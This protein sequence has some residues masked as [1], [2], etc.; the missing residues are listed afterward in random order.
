MICTRTAF[1]GLR[2]QFVCG[3][4]A[5]VT[6][7]SSLTL[8]GVTPAIA[9]TAV[10]PYLMSPTASSERTMM[11]AVDQ[12][13]GGQAQAA[14]PQQ[15]AAPQQSAAPQQGDVV[16]PLSGG[17]SLSPISTL[18]DDL[19]A[20]RGVPPFG[21][22][23]FMQ[24]SQLIRPQTVNPNYV[25]TPGDQIAIQIWGAQAFSGTQ[26]VDPQGN[27]FVP[28]IGPVAVAGRTVANVNA[29]ISAAVRRVFTSNVNAYVTVLSRQPVGVYVSGAVRAP[30]HYAGEPNGSPLGF[31]VQA[32]GIDPVSGSFRDI[33]LLR[34]GATVARI[35]L[36]AFLLSG[37]MPV[38]EFRENDSLFVGR[39][40]PSVTVH[41]EAQNCFRFEIPS[42]VVT[43]TD[44]VALARPQPAASHV[45]LR[46]VR[47]NRPFNAYLPLAEFRGAAVE[48]GDDVTFITDR[49]TESIVVSVIGQ[50]GGPSS[51]AVPRNAPLGEVLKL[52]E[53]DPAT[54][55]LSS[56]YLRRASVAERQAR[57][58]EMSLGELQ[59][60]ALTSTATTITEAGIRNQEA[61]LIER[62]IAK[63][64][65]ARPE[66]RVVLAGTPDR[67]DLRLE[68]NDVIVLPARS[69]VVIIAGEV[70]VPQTLMWRKG[71]S[72]EDYVELAG[73]FSNR[74]SRGDYVI[75][76]RNG[77]ALIGSSLDV[78]PGDQVMVMPSPGDKGFAV[79]HDL[80]EVLYRVAVSTAVVINASKD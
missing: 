72:I 36:Y 64:R 68:D 63:A 37:E 22:Q 38:V 18:S 46:G 67:D 40:G 53:V 24:N 4:V 56:I 60:T 35:D 47:D 54:T 74:A 30:G 49:V 7:M 19:S 71:L 25:I 34:Q 39:Q 20:G 16:R 1:R 43:G 12:P 28:E 57:A 45:A 17:T 9:Q 11:Q 14:S 31:L 48:D 10:L 51:F 80:I 59:R 65:M 6:V 76:R 32:G 23:L 75:I 58:L 69:Q 52:V 55:D 41:G 33:R 79:F 73:G 62:F 77:Q 29:T 70:R 44:I 42:G 15:G 2:T 50:S 13:F 27:I 21:S 78:E 61:A 8:G 26:T 3:I 5:V 66:G